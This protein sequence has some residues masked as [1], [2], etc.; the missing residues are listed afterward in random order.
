MK[1]KTFE[2][3][4]EE[5][6]T[7]VQRL[8]NDELPLDEALKLF[9]QGIK[10]SRLCTGKLDEAEKKVEILL[11]DENGSAERAPFEEPEQQ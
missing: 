11:Q 2:Q 7:I 3:A 5:L 4:Q 8:E 10:L 9:E 6:E 1:N